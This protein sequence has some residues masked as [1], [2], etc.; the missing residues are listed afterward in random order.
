MEDQRIPRTS[1]RRPVGPGRGPTARAPIC[2]AAIAAT[3]AFGCAHRSV[4]SRS[5]PSPPITS[6]SRLEHR[7]PDVVEI[8]HRV[9]NGETLY[10]IAKMYG[11][12]PEALASANRISDP[13]KLAP[14]QVA[15]YRVP[16]QDQAGGH[17][18][19]DAGQPG[20]VGLARGDHSQRHGC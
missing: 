5:N 17:P 7:E 12:S 10:R 1:S 6:A 2:L 11:I 19:D 16:V 4:E 3:F 15:I 8:R 14:G 13:T 9:E 20:T 18:L